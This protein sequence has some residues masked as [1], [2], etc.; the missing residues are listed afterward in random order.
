MKESFPFTSNECVSHARL[1]IPVARANLTTEREAAHA[2]FVLI[3]N[4]SGV[5]FL[6]ETASIKGEAGTV[7]YMELLRSNGNFRL[8]WLG[9]VVSQLGDWFNTIAVYTLIINLTGSKSALGLLLVT[10]FL[11]TIFLAPLAGVVAD[12]FNRRTLMI[13]S[14]VLRALVVLGFLFIRRPEQLWMVYALTVLQLALSSFFEPAK[15]ASVPSVVSARELLPANAIASVTWSAMLTL[16]AAVGGVVTGSFGTDAAFIIDSFSYLLSAVFIFRLRLPKRPPRPKTRLTLAKALG[17]ADMRAGLSYVRTRPRILALMLVKPSWGLGGGILTLLAVF[18]ESV[19]R[20]GDNAARGIGVL[21]AARG[22]GTGLGPLIA[23]RLGGE[24]KRS[25]ETIIGLSFFV[26]GTFYMAF[27]ASTNFLLALLFLGL[28]HMGGSVL[29]VYSTTLLQGAVV[30]EFRGRVFAAEL[31][32][33]TA[34]LALSNFLTGEALDRF[35]ISPRAVTIFIGAFFLAPGVV[36]LVTR[37]LWDVGGDDETKR[38][39][40]AFDSETTQP[41]RARTHGD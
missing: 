17:I 9:Q 38:L 19:F 40:G 33:I 25:M 37:K 41:E 4:L 10:R 39:A 24:S 35:Q 31:A 18:G 6:T 27:G 12:R 3:Q 21:Y 26:G 8:L 23:R 15:S 29:W 22:V 30:D 7:G 32:L 2:L 13:A 1:A 28:A 14:D 5:F 11:P 20:M 36:W 16:G 34:T